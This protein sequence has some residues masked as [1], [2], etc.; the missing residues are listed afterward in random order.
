VYNEE[1]IPH[2]EETPFENP[3]LVGYRASIKDSQCIEVLE[4]LE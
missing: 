3:S 2:F 4:E 1:E